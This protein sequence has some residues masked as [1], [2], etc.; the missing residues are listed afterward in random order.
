MS[1]PVFRVMTAE[2]IASSAGDTMIRAQCAGRV[3]GGKRRCR[4]RSEWLPQS[5]LLD[6]DGHW[7]CAF[8]LGG[9]AFDGGQSR[10]LP[11]GGE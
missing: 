7:F 10:A 6:A 11:R 9:P 2:E 8:H 4:N 5:M 1:E 3:Y